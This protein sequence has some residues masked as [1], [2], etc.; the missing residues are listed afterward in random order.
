[1]STHIWAKVEIGSEMRKI[2]IK[3]NFNS[4]I[5]LTALDLV[6]QFVLLAG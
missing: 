6:A 2:K 5:S 1:M 3:T 4:F